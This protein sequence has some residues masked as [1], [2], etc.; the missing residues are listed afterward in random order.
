MESS[1]MPHTHAGTRH[2]HTTLACAAHEPGGLTPAGAPPPGAASLA[3]P[4][5]ALKA[6]ALLRGPAGHIGACQDV[7]ILRNGHLRHRV[8]IRELKCEPP[9]WHIPAAPWVSGLSTFL[10][11]PAAGGG[12]TALHAS[13]RPAAAEAHATG[14]APEMAGACTKRTRS[15]AP[16]TAPISSIRQKLTHPGFTPRPSSGSH[17]GPGA[18]LAHTRLSTN[19]TELSPLVTGH[20]CPSPLPARRAAH[21]PAWAL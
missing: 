15:G 19:P 2:E 13:N 4:S 6:L 3:P 14:Q 16:D 8:V 10:L 1:G 11:R 17:G 5:L 18:A 9:V 7:G 21:L 12:G 20:P